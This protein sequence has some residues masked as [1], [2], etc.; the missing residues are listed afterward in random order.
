M[1]SPIHPD[2]LSGHPLRCRADVEAL[3]GRIV[4]NVLPFLSAGGARLRLGGLAH[5]Y[6]EAGAQM[7]GMARQLWG[8]AP[9]VAGGGA[10]DGFDRFVQG[11]ANGTD[12]SHPEYW[13]DITD[14]DQ[15]M[16]EMAAI[17]LTLALSGDRVWS[18][19]E[20]P[21]RAR[22]A[23][24]LGSINRR[25]PVNNNWHFF[26]VL[27]NLGLQRVGAPSHEAASARSLDA[28]ESFYLGNGW[29]RDGM[30]GGRDHYVAFAF[31]F[32]GLIYAR[33]ADDLDPGRAARFRERAG[34]FAPA[35]RTWFA[36]D[37]AS[38]PFGRSLTYRFAQGAFW[39]ALAF[40]DVEAL[41]WAEVKGLFMRHLRWWQGRPIFERDGVL[42]IGY[43]YPNYLMS[44]QYNAAG[45]PYW[46]L[47]AAL[48]LTLP[49]GHPFWAADEASP[50]EAAETR[51]IPEAGMIVQ[52]GGGHV[53]ALGVAQQ[54]AIHRGAAEKYA[55]LA[56][57]SHFG[58]SV[59][60]MFRLAE[61]VG[62]NALLLSDD[63]LHVRTREAHDAW[64]VAMDHVRSRWRPWPD[65]V[66]E[67]WVF[68]AHPWHVRV[69]RIV[70][71]RPLT[72][73]EGGFALPIGEDEAP[74]DIFERT[75]DAPPYL[76]GR[77][78]F[79]GLFAAEA[80]RASRMT[81]TLPS[82]NVIHRRTIVPKLEAR[83]PPGETVLATAVLGTPRAED[84]RTAWATP[85]DLARFVARTAE[86]P[87]DEEVLARSDAS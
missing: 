52:T 73:S 59:E 54:N 37:G 57:S 51:P 19:L 23:A 85:P 70:S 7:E 10:F 30:L 25:E 29:Y 34:A 22:A 38:L 56:Y 6:G 68:P 71:R 26:R 8:L 42:S 77:F 1:P 48:P 12:P 21:Q 40:A 4:G 53:V 41:P 80:G 15:R 87:R 83:H 84:G 45:S 28:I 60:S 18:A 9:L 27:V 76:S 67:S 36:P 32:Y 49:E 5:R 86:P 3:V 69:H 72:S 79:S 47:K 33:L 58:F 11:I 62:D 63:G 17:G 61:A 74:P 82:T 78:G 16:V 55:K 50:R 81:V 31:H 24:W 35:Y 65:V 43:G 39:G 14:R 13:G 75:V 20:A 66:V 44:E 46:A 2:P 64:L